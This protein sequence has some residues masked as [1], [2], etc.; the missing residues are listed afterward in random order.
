MTGVLKPSG[1]DAIV[2]DGVTLECDVI[3]GYGEVTGL[4]DNLRVV[5]A[6]PVVC[7]SISGT[8]DVACKSD[9]FYRLVNCILQIHVTRD[10]LTSLLYLALVGFFYR[11]I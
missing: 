7:D 6:C 11:C 2:G 3:A 1:R 4:R 10:T 5:S 9:Y 8:A